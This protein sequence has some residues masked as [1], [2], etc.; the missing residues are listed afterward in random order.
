MIKLVAVGAFFFTVVT[1]N[2]GAFF[3][4]I[5]AETLVGL[6]QTVFEMV[7]LVAAVANLQAVTE[8]FPNALG[9]TVCARANVQCSENLESRFNSSVL[10]EKPKNSRFHSKF[11]VD[12]VRF[13]A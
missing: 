12:T 8:A 6:A 1:A 4:A 10:T 3:H 9:R 7:K 11:T 5:F 13:L 2:A